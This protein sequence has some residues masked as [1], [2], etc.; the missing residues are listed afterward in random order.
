MSWSRFLQTSTNLS[1]SLLKQASSAAASSASNEFIS[2]VRS[3]TVGRACSDK[4]VSDLAAP[5]LSADD[6]KWCTWALDKQGGGVV[7]GHSWGQLLEKSQKERFDALNCNAVSKGRNPSCDDAWGDKHLTNW[8]KNKI[9]GASSCSSGHSSVS[10]FHNENSDNYCVLEKAQINF[11]KMHFVDRMKSATYSSNSRTFDKGFL[12]VDCDAAGKAS[13][14]DSSYFPFP[15]LYSS[16]ISSDTCDYVINGTVLLYSHDDIRNLGHMMNDIM[17]VWVML[18]LDQGRARQASLTPFLNID[19]FKLGHNFQDEPNAFFETYFRNFGAFI[20]GSSFPSKSTVCIERVLIQPIP[21]MFFVWTSWFKD[22]PCTFLGPSSAYQRWNMHVRHSYGLLEPSSLVTNNRI[23]VFLVVRNETRNLWG[24][25]R[26]SRNF[27]EYETLH[28]GLKSLLQEDSSLSLAAGGPPISFLAVDL[29]RY[30]F[31]QQLVLLS[32]SSI[33]IGMH[34]A[35]LASAMHMSIGTKYCCG[36]I[37]IFPRGEFTP[38]RGHG[39]MLRKMGFLYDRLDLPEVVSKPTG[40]YVPPDVLIK[41]IRELISKLIKEPT[42]IVPSV[43]NDPY[44]EEGWS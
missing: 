27:I 43:I 24:A 3:A 7:V 42:C 40:A 4:V 22:L 28:N 29:S 11:R 39:N 20:K 8:G 5:S 44:L 26:T 12:S 38:I 30:T 23:Q 10:C 9:P 37:E 2:L 32:E 15:H 13:T 1:S 14:K 33:I 17:N 6:F 41:P 19:S 18:W 25:S 36:A 34:G 31:Q 21:P 35:G 16:R